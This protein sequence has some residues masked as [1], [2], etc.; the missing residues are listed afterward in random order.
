MTASDLHQRI[1]TAFASFKTDSVRELRPEQRRVIDR[2][3]GGGRTLALFPTGAGKSLCYQVSGRA[4]GGTTIVISPLIAL[5][6]EQA[7]KLS[8]LGRH[9]H[10]LHTQIPPEKQIGLLRRWYRNEIDI[11]YL[12]MSP[13]RLAM[14]VL[15]QQALRAKA[16][17]IR[18][19][20][21]DEA[22][23]ISEWGDDFRPLYT[24]IPATLD[25]IFGGRS[26]WPSLLA[27]TATIGAKDLEVIQNDFGITYCERHADLLRESIHLEVRRYAN[28][29]EK[30]AALWSCL[31]ETGGERTVAFHY[32]IRGDNGVEDLAEQARSRGLMAAPFHAR[33]TMDAKRRTI[34]SFRNGT[35]NI[36]FATSAFG[37]GMDIPNI[38]TALHI[39]P[40]PS[41]EEYYQQVGRAGRDGKPAKAIALYTGMNHMIRKLFLDQFP[42]DDKIKAVFAQI[43]GSKG[44]PGFK[45]QNPWD[46]DDETLAC[47]H[48]L[49][50]AGAVRIVGPGI[51]NL[52]DFTGSGAAAERRLRALAETSQTGDLVITAKRLGEDPCTL[53]RELAD[54]VLAGTVRSEKTI[55][56]VM[57]LEVLSAELDESRLAEACR[58]RDRVRAAK[59]NDLDHIARVFDEYK[60]SASLHRQIAAYLGYVDGIDE[61]KFD[62]AA[63]VRVRSKNEVIIANALH[64]AGIPFDYELDIVMGGKAWSPG[65]D[66]TISSSGLI[67]EHLGMLDRQNYRKKWEE[68]R[69]Q[70]EKHRP[71]K[72]LIT[73]DQ[74]TLGGFVDQI[75]GWIQSGDDRFASLDFDWQLGIGMILDPNRRSRL[76][77]L[78]HTTPRPG[79]PIGAHELVDA[80]HEVIGQADIAFPGAV[81]PLAVVSDMESQQAYEKAGWIV[82]NVGGS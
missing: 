16:S 6:D 14:N 63:G 13:E 35:T 26:H 69:A 36:L 28:E 22:H 19:V 17:Q 58:H 15:V 20:A 67:W 34:D 65:P 3:V 54:G 79:P 11:E 75:L 74:H 38:R 18:L 10:A 39:R 80:S 37:L 51:T 24:M 53:A 78:A 76:L 2:I 73:H 25:A 44:Q 60:D 64:H 29:K 42:D 7:E 9:A 23:C 40:P 77:A 12:F 8:R 33:L 62:T 50:L 71:G 68:K 48:Y 5:M 59:S 43:I 61:P 45:S 32:K 47:V 41:I 4:L 66:F 27:M 21:I 81:P 31:A 55:K 30:I 1:D 57:V 49:Q 56:Q 46:E 70:Y 52:R 72:V 82:L